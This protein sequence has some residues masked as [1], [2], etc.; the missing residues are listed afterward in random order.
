MTC[1]VKSVCITFIWCNLFFHDSYKPVG[2][3]TNV[4]C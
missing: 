2:V 3:I 1:F 4:A